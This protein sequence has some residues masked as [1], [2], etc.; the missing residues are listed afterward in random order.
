MIE[1]R[2]R[3]ESSRLRMLMTY[4]QVQQEIQR[5]ERGQKSAQSAGKLEK[6]GSKLDFLRRLALE[7]KANTEPV[8]YPPHKP[9]GELIE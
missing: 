9:S 3:W 7:R 8:K 5:C 4:A 2:N 1:P 6:W